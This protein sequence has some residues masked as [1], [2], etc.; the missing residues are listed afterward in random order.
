MADTTDVPTNETVELIHPSGKSIIANYRD[1]V[2][3]C[4]YF[5]ILYEDLNAPAKYALSPT[6][7]TWS[8]ESFEYFI[9]CMNQVS[10]TN[11]VDK[12]NFHQVSKFFEHVPA[13]MAVDIVKTRN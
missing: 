4:K 10:G 13:A 8:F 2:Q 9:A 3:H 1:L 12:L 7:F 5:R 6:R 11:H